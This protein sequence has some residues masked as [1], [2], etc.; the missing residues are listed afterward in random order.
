MNSGFT[1]LGKDADRVA[2]PK[3]I[4]ANSNEFYLKLLGVQT[5]MLGTGLT[6]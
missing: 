2:Y 3:E 5:V 4:L 1:P 6:A